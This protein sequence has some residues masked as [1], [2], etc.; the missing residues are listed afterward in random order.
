MSDRKRTYD[1][2]CTRIRALLA[3][4]RDRLELHEKTY[5]QL[6]TWSACGDTYHVAEMLDAVNSHL[7]P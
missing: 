5:G 4:I 1:D 6:P 7:A 2:N 3:S